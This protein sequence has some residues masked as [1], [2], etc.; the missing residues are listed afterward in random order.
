VLKG[1]L[2]MLRAAAL[3]FKDRVLYYEIGR[4]PNLEADWSGTNVAEYA[5]VLKN[6]SVTVR[7]ADPAALIAEGAL[8]IAGPSPDEALAW[9]KALYAQEVATY[10]DALPVRPSPGADLA[11]TVRRGWDLLLDQDPSAAIWVVEDVPAGATD[12]E[13]AADLLRRFVVAEGEGA[14][15]VSFNLEADVEGRPEFPGVLLDIHRL[16][17]PGYVRR[18]GEGVRFATGGEGAPPGG[19]P[20]AGATPMIAGVHSYRFFD[21]VTYQGLVAFFTDE[22]PAEPQATLLL[23]TA[24]VKGA[25][26]YDLAGGPRAL[27]WGR[28]PISRP[29]RRGSR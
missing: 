6:S 13:R 20:G 19:A 24:A 17:Q 22:R 3:H 25:A 28:G 12:R 1:W 15:L 29:T 9:Q 7:S 16:F 18:P 5:F 21:A 23:D 26:V 27:R 2:E 11:A 8:A 10:V 4:A 14:A